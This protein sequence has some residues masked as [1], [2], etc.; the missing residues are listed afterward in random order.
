MAF[1]CLFV[2]SCGSDDPINADVAIQEFIDQ[3]SITYQETSSGLYY[4]INSEGATPLASSED[5]VAFDLKGQLL[6]GTSIGNTFGTDADI[7]LYLDQNI[8]PGIGEAVQFLGTGGQGSFI[9]PAELAFGSIGNGVVPANTPVAYDIEVLGIYQDDQDYS[10]EVLSDYITA[11]GLEITEKTPSGL[12]VVIEEPGNDTKPTSSE[13]VTV[14]YEGYFLNGD[15]FDSSIA[16]GNPSTFLLNQVIAGWTEGI[17]YFGEGG[18][19][20]LLI[21]AHL[22]YGAG[23]QS[24]PAYTPLVFDI[25]LISVN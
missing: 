11:E 13:A 2:F 22:A 14:H 20:K 7:H 4:S 15:V 5:F 9:L 18:K 8:L 6:D 19:G 12:Y 23:S 1:S 21:P 3:S 24:I 16:R 25:E 17:P 10:D